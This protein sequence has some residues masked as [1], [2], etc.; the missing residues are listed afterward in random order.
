MKH[1]KYIQKEEVVQLTSTRAGEE[2]LGQSIELIEDVNNLSAS[3]APF[4]L[5]GICEDIGVKA[6]FGRPGCRST[7]KE[8]LK[9]FLNVQVNRFLKS[10]T[11]SLGPYLD[12][13][14]WQSEADKLEV[15]N[16]HD[17]DKLR[18]LVSLI[19]AEVA[20]LVQAIR[21]AGKVPIVIGGGHNNSY[22]LIKGS[23]Q[24]NGSGINVLNI[25]PHAD[26]RSLEGRHSGNG[27]SYAKNDNYLN[28]YAVFGLHESYNNQQ[29]LE[30][31]RASA[32]L[33]YLSYD[34]LLAYSTDERDRL[35][36]DALRWLGPGPTGLELDTDSLQA[37]PASALNASGFTMRQARLMVKTAASLTAP[38]YFHLAE[39]APDLASNANEKEMSTK[40]LVYL[41]TD[42]VK[43][44][45]ERD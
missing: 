21:K 16:A 23:A 1:L 26:F 28:R 12:F 3:Q 42:F 14:D 5:V 40:A 27:F 36:K 41:I 33:Y 38:V 31:F 30:E 39:A 45:P 18:D 32:D 29:I 7:F 37:F 20:S 13:E 19:D 34:E 44:Y 2:K 15:S 43:S 11:I 22:G 9:P 4:V 17:L 8:F 24:V 25:D 10:K 35:F 6:N